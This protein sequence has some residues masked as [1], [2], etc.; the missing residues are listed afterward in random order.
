MLEFGKLIAKAKS[1]RFHLWLLNRLLPRMIPFNA[2]HGYTVT[3]IDDEEV[4]CTLPLK[5]RNLNHIR[6][7]HACALATLAEFVTG[8]RLLTKLDVK[9]YRIIMQRIEM[10][11]FYQGRT[12]AFASFR[13]GD[14]WMEERVTK[15]LENDDAVVVDCEIEIHDAKQNHLCTGRVFWQV[16]AWKKVR[17]RV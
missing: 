14:Q 10:E 6:G 9:K 3:H 1:S 11:Y 13:L 12:D 15:P 8:F 17:L 2:G 7:L 4:R 5:R 16:K